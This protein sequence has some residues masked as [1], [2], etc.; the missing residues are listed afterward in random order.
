MYG[1]HHSNSTKEKLRKANEGKQLKEETKKKIS[2]SHKGKNH[3]KTK[4]VVLLNTGE[5]FDYIK[6]ASEKYNVAWQ[7]ISACCRGR[8]KSAGKDE[9]GNKLVWKYLDLM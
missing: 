9:N 6:Q 5:T 4:K 7:S 8:L 1:K 3:P 2:E